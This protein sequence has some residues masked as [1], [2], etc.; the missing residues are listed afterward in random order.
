[1]DNLQEVFR[2]CRKH[3]LMIGLPKCE[4]S[5]SKI[6]FLGHLLSA[7]GCSPLQKHSAAIYAFPPPSD[8][9]AL[10][11]SLR[12]LN[13]YREFLL[14]ADGILA[15]LTDALKGPGKSLTWSPAL[16]FAFCR[17]KDLLASVP[18]LVHPLPGAQISLAVDTSEYHVSS[19]L[20]QLPGPPGFLLQE[21]V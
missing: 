8:K 4:Y 9:P 6:E 17:A 1:M 3:G 20:Q 18:E 5:V 14:G 11:R 21:A 10:Q 19:V 2:H 13:F 15:P 12:M 16:D 7:S